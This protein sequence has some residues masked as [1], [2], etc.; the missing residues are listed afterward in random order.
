MSLCYF[1][2]HP[3]FFKE[4]FRVRMF[5]VFRGGAF[6]WAL[7][8]PG[9]QRKRDGENRQEEPPILCSWSFFLPPFCLTK[10][11]TQSVKGWFVKNKQTNK[12]KNPQKYSLSSL[13]ILFWRGG[14]RQHS[15]CPAFLWILVWKIL[16]FKHYII[17][18]SFQ[19][20]FQ[21]SQALIIFLILLKSFSVVFHIYRMAFILNNHFYLNSI[22]VTDEILVSSWR[23]ECFIKNT[24]C[25]N[26]I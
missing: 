9:G 8:H 12:Q 24:F 25:Y 1:Y 2:N 17:F 20:C 6:Y 4:R 18:F 22:H 26:K 15:F 13:D 5:V 3:P 14:R 23:E 19:I 11:L 21:C 16:I 7:L 10:D